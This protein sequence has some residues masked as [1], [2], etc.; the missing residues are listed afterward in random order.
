MSSV[1]P[2]YLIAITEHSMCQ[3][4]RPGPIGGVPER[5]A[6][7]G[8]LPER[9]IARVGLLVLVHIHARAGQIAAEIVVRELAVRRETGDLEVD[10]AVARVGVLPS[11]SRSMALDHVVDVFGG[12]RQPLRP[13]QA[14]RGAIFQKGVGIDLRVFVERLVLGHG[15]ANDL[16]VHVGDIHHVVQLEAIGAAGTCAAGPRT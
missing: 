15:V 1:S 10:R 7:L 8:R 13:L 12:R 3:P 5:L 9:K 2:R 11:P 4:G 16:V 6:V 14:Q